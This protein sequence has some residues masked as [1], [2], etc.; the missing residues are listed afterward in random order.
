[1]NSL[2]TTSKLIK[3]LNEIKIQNNTRRNTILQEDQAN[4]INSINIL[5]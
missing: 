3:D 4:P 5:L 2:S 1:M